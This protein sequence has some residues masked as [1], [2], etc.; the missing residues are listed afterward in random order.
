[1][2]RYSSTDSDV[3]YYTADIINNN[4]EDPIGRSLDPQVSLYSQRQFPIL[5][6]SSDYM[7]SVVRLS[8]SG[9]TRNLPLWIPRIQT[10]SIGT[11]FTARLSGAVMTLSAQ[12]TQGS[13]AVGAKIYGTGTA[14][15]PTP[16]GLVSVF[17]TLEFGTDGLPLTIALAPAPPVTYPA[18]YT[19]S[20]PPA[21]IVY[22]GVSYT[23]YSIVSA[24]LYVGAT[25]EDPN[26]TEYSVTLTIPSLGGISDQTYLQWKP[27]NTYLPPPNQIGVDG[28]GLPVYVPIITQNLDTEYYYGYTYDNVVDMLNIALANSVSELLTATGAPPTPLGTPPTFSWV[29]NAQG[30]AIFTLNSDT[31][32]TGSNHY[33]NVAMNSNLTSLLPNFPGIFLNEGNGQT[34]RIIPPAGFKSASQNYGGTSAWSPVDAIVL[35]SSTLPIQVEQV[36]PPGIVGGSDTGSSTITSPAAFQPILLD[37]SLQD[38]VGAETWRKDFVYQPSAEYRMISMNNSNAPIQTVDIQVWWR[39]R[40]DNNLYPL[41]LTNNSSMSVKLMFRR[42][43]MG[44]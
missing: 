13:L 30:E 22:R 2:S 39:N 5:Q 36:S 24:S 8:S 11:V 32:G 27:E 25:Q 29:A 43:Q 37:I 35:T 18:T 3:L 41:R 42:K 15:L 16:Q 40:Y 9:A 12:P 23:N 34:F 1:M 21:P 14:Q 31:Y 19:L 33:F 20:A 6:D 4:A 44:V 38:T 17:T 7:L 26:L 10:S 28:G